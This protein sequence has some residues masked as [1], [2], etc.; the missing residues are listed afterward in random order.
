MRQPILEK[1]QDRIDAVFGAGYAA[2]H[3]DLVGSYL[4]Y[5]AITGLESTLMPL[6]KAL[7]DQLSEDLLAEECKHAGCN[8]L[9]P[10]QLVDE[11]IAPLSQEEINRQC[12]ELDDLLNAEE[13]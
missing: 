7:S 5:E 3:S 9:S 4:I 11:I 10:D 12:Q 6:H 1:I 2:A 8:L 13:V